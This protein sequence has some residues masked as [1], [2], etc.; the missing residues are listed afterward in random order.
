MYHSGLSW[1]GLAQQG[2]A[3]VCPLLSSSLAKLGKA[4][5]AFVTSQ[6]VDLQNRVFLTTVV[7][8]WMRTQMDFSDTDY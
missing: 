8:K 3:G 7:G 6:G 1:S 4:A 2:R 5:I